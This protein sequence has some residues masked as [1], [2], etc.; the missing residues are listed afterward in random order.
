MNKREIW[1]RPPKYHGSNDNNKAL[2]RFA[3][4]ASGLAAISDNPRIKSRLMDLQQRLQYRVRNGSNADVGY[5][6]PAI[7]EDFLLLREA[8]SSEHKTEIEIYLQQLEKD[9]QKLSDLVRNNVLVTP[10]DDSVDSRVAKLM[11]KNNEIRN[12]YRR[13][14]DYLRRM[15]QQLSRIE[16]E[17]LT[18]P[19]GEEE[20]LE[21]QARRLTTYCES[22]E[23]AVRTLADITAELDELISL[24]KSSP[25]LASQV[26][27]MIKIRCLADFVVHPIKAQRQREKLKQELYYIVRSVDKSAELTATWNDVLYPTMFNQFENTDNQRDGVS[28]NDSTQISMVQPDKFEK[29][30]SEKHKNL[31]TKGE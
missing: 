4:M 20:R 27:R 14:A 29:S 1:K 8:I 23:K 10:W 11:Q 31:L 26:N 16:T 28:R 25:K 12:V 22:R 3:T 5:Y 24:S 18:M 30:T 13:N 19:A 15:R 17:L 9:T 2:Q 6:I 7:F 21:L